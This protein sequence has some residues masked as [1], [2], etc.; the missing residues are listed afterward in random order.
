MEMSFLK[1]VISKQAWKK[2]PIVFA[3]VYCIETDNRL[4]YCDWIKTPVF[5]SLAL[6]A[7]CKRLYEAMVILDSKAVR[8]EQH[9][10]E[11]WNFF[12]R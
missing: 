1:Y 3:S 12:F 9:H 8:S 2:Q 10:A 7:L 11:I 6:S 5:S 4:Y